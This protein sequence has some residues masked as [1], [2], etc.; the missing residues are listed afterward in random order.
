MKPP[1]RRIRT[2]PAG[3]RFDVRQQQRNP[4]EGTGLFT[5]SGN[6]FPVLIDE[7]PACRPGNAKALGVP[8]VQI[9]GELVRE[10]ARSLAICGKIATEAKSDTRQIKMRRR[11]TNLDASR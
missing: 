3:L 8:L 10:D 6:H 9:V 1:M 2:I 11:G 4:N 5:A 7:M